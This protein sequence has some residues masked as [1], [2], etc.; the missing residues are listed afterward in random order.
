MAAYILVLVVGLA[1]GAVSAIIGTGSS[2]MLLPLLVY[3]FGPKQAVPIMAIAGLMAN[4]G[5][6][7]SWWREIDWRAFAA[8]AIPGIPAAALGARTLLVLPSAWSMRRSARLLPADD[9][10]AAGSPRAS[11]SSSLW[12]LA[13]RGRGDR[14]P[15]RHRHLDRA[16]ERPGLHGLRPH[17]GAFLSTEAATSLALFVTKVA[18]FREFGALP[19]ASIIAGLL[20]GASVILGSFIGKAVVQRIA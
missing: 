11:S 13:A 7:V 12:Q 3:Q 16:A 17:Q 14:L 9:P 15:H 19:L 6:V 4:V 1:A 5:K 2:I 20:I 8:Y 18:T 10:D